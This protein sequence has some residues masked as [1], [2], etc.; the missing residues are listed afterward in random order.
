MLRE[1]QEE[2]V[3]RAQWVLIEKHRVGFLVN[4]TLAI[5]VV[6]FLLFHLLFCY[7]FFIVKINVEQ[8]L[9]RV[10]FQ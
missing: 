2:G 4:F 8:D 7:D 10:F 5:L 9:S 3:I 1:K 6:I